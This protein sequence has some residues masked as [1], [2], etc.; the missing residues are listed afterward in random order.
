MALTKSNVDI[1][2]AQGLDTK[3]DPKRVQVGRFLALAN[4]IFA[5]T[6][7]QKRNGFNELPSI[8]VLDTT[9]L[10]TFSGSLTAIGSSLYNYA[11][12]TASW[13]DKGD[14][15]SVSTEVVSLVRS[16]TSQ[17][18][19]DTAVTAAGLACSVW[20]DSDGTSKYQVNDTSSSQVI[21]L[22]TLPST[23][24]QPRVFVLGKYF[25]VT[26]LLT[27]SAVTHM[28][29]VA[30]PISSPTS[31]LAQQDL[32]LQ[33]NSL[34]AGY[35]AFVIG[36]N[37]YYAW[38]DSAPA[39]KIAYLSNTLVAASAATIPALN[40]ALIS[41]TGDP[42]T[43]TL[44]VTYWDSS[45]TDV[46]VTAYDTRLNQ[47]LAPQL[48][49]SDNRVCRLASVADTN[50]TLT[51]FYE[52]STTYTFSS[53]PSHVI[54]CFTATI[55][56]TQTCVGNIT[57]GSKILT[58]TSGASNIVIG[59]TLSGL[60]IASGAYVTAKTDTTLTMSNA[61]IANE[62]GITVTAIPGFTNVVNR[63]AGIASKPVIVNGTRYIM[64]A[65][66][67]AYQP[68]YFLAAIQ[69]SPAPDADTIGRICAKLA[70][71]NGGGY[72]T[73]QVVPQAN[74]S[75]NTIKIG[76]L[77]KD[78]LTSV[79][80]T[81]GA[82][83]TAGVYSQTGVN[84]VSWTVNQNVMP[85][86][87]IGNNLHLAGGFLWMYDGSAPVEHGFHL[88]PE[89]MKATP[90][91]T[92]GSMTAQ[93][94]FYQVTYEWT[95]AQGNIHRSAP[96]VPLAVT[97][98]GSG[99][100]SVLLDIPAL[101]LTYKQ[102]VRVVIYRWST[103]QQTYYQITSVSAPLVCN[104]TDDYVTYTDTQADSAILGNQ[105]IY[106]TGGVL[107]NIAFPAVNDITLFRSRLVAIDAEDPNQIWYSKQVIETTPVEPSDSL[108][109]YVAP[110]Q[111]AQGSTGVNTALSAMDD[112]LI[113]FK[114]DAIYYMTGIGPDNTGANNDFQDPS[115][116][117][118]TAGC[119]N[120]ASIVFM[121]QGLMFQSDKGI[122]LLGR[123]LSTTYIGAPVEAYNNN[124]VL[125]AL[126]IPGTNQVRFTLDNGVTLV[127]DYYYNQWGTFTG[128]P[129]ISSTLY[130]NLHTFVND[131][132]AVY[133]E[134]PGAYLDGSNPVL[135]NFK[136]GW[137]SF[138]GLQGF[139]RAYYFTLLAQYDSPHKL[140]I[141]IAYDYDP[142]VAQTVIISPDNYNPTYGESQGLYGN[143]SPF[144]GNSNVEQ[145]R[146]FLARQKC[147]S[148]QIT[149]TE[150]YDPSLGVVAGAGFSMSGL[151]MV[152]GLKKGYV[153][154]KASRSAG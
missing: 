98:G 102:N 62:T 44:W 113:I 82:S 39:L 149:V 12:E 45:S 138:A 139:E 8:P 112:K 114:R 40:P 115:Y 135:M 69:N 117:T 127:Y 101:R 110:T 60:G 15:R 56:L 130:Q 71:S 13:F 5:N 154:L 1:S 26:Y 68:T 151:N 124:T 66:N 81:Q 73:G 153:P 9:T 64:I 119:A 55:S 24:T 96:S 152:V 79:N 89:D 92:G 10:T 42:I 142:S 47:L 144:G 36:N 133:Q 122:W 59:T 46:A 7:L 103:A 21:Y 129:G 106:T 11:S 25:I 97:V 14:I 54:W 134:S 140:Q 120:P 48:V 3:T 38:Y 108:T 4:S 150:I 57:A 16:S 65:Y 143:E 116:I 20:E 72:P 30:V 28:Q 63:G 105:I 41:V 109:I 118:S 84:L 91:T 27:V 147:Q 136:T 145:W 32:A 34:T 52:L 131:L 18:A 87:E 19:Q 70:Y 58:L 75:G 93:D 35:D 17:S 85:P 146:V 104:V 94:Y 148:F 141:D 80:K 67:G 128:I 74:L 43:S 78:L 61:A 37:L 53:T 123:D 111:G 90:S 83:T 88:W 51:A 132:G 22:A 121:P 77:Y 2:F 76:Y 86:A 137:L 100:G 125:S 95:D 126:N 49:T 107:E 33:V 31:P 23:A 29:Y 6:S 99:S 50:G